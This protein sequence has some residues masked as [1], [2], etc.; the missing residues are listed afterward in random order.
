MRLI[1]QE[2]TPPDAILPRKVAA[3]L[4]L[5][6]E[7]GL[8]PQAGFSDDGASGMVT[9]QSSSWW[10]FR[11]CKTCGHT[12]RRGDRV[13]V[14]AMARTVKHLTPGLN[15]GSDAESAVVAGE[16][17]D[18]FTA[19]LLFTWPPMVSITR[20]G[21]GDWRIPRPGST[22]Q[23]PTCLY[24]GHTFRAGEYVVVC[25]CQSDQGRPPACATAVHRDPAA[26]LPC[27][28]NWQ[29]SG[30]LTICPTTTVKL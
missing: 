26:G 3:E 6:I 12:F 20:I 27:W 15:C 22:W 17:R 25:P 28:D 13:L 24:C 18:A 11:R 29:P 10:N 9:T 5:G 19:G 21:A 14:D 30:Q 4:T 2:A 7:V 8:E 23:A 16:D 1:G